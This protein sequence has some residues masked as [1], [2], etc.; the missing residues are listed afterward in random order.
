MSLETLAE[1]FSFLKKY[2]DGKGVIVSLENTWQS[3]EEFEYILKHANG[4]MTTIDISHA[5]MQG[6]MPKIEEFLQ[7]FRNSMVHLHISD[8]NGKSDSHEEIGKGRIPFHTVWKLIKKIDYNGTVTLEVFK[9]KTAVKR[10][11]KIIKDM[12]L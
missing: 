8:N 9:D 11:L 4:V 5:Y 3:P 7:R 1:S 6:G 10:S 2:G 12:W